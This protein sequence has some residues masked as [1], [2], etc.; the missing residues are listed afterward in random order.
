MGRHSLAFSV[1]TV[2]LLPL[3]AVAWCHGI[4][5]KQQRKLHGTHTSSCST[6]RPNKMISSGCWNRHDHRRHRPRDDISFSIGLYMIAPQQLGSFET[7]PRIDMVQRPLVR[8]RNFV[9][10]SSS[11]VD[12]EQAW[13]L[14]RA[15]LDEQL[16]FLAANGGAAA[17]VKVPHDG[18]QSSSSRDELILLEHNPVYTLGTASDEKFVT[19][20]GGTVP[21]VRM[22]RGGEVTYHGPGQLTAYPILNLKR[23]KQDIHWYVRAL[24]EVVILALGECGLTAV[25]EENL[26]GV[27]VD[28]YK[29]AA[30]GV[31]CKRWVTQHG[32]AINVTP[33]SLEHFDGIVPCGLEGRKVGCVQQFLVND[34]S[35]SPTATPTTATIDVATV[36]E[37][38]KVAFEDVFQVKLRDASPAFIP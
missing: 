30:I 5:G 29:V 4:H 20:A 38:V 15:I 8:C 2:A 6:G 25:R 31:K 10:S 18:Q 7:L 36:A 14:Q 24:E 19:V 32:L 17:K 21:V 13:Q 34:D 23:Y 26:T 35:S 33:Q 12:F 37:Y 27:F 16:R 11:P 22:D 3:L 1:A 28:G 9:G